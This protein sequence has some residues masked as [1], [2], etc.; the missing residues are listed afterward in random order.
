VDLA[1]NVQ[2][3]RRE[4][5]H[6]KL[7]RA[8]GPAYDQFDRADWR[9]GFGTACEVVDQE[10]RRYLTHGIRKSKIVLAS[11]AGRPINLT[12]AGIQKLT[13]GQLAAQFE[14]I[15]GPNQ[16]DSMIAKALKE[17]NPDRNAHRHKKR[18]MEEQLRRNV[19]RDMYIIIQALKALLDVKDPPRR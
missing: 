1:V 13:L 11:P 12:P 4:T 8:L 18:R 7:R 2:L 15:Q 16:R 9:E 19:G 10:A 3:P 6:P 14:N 5:L 17:I